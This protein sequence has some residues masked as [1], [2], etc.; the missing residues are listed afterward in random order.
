M[1][2]SPLAFL[3][4]ALLT[5]PASA[6][7]DATSCK[8][9][10]HHVELSATT[11]PEPAQVCISPGQVT[12]INFDG[13]LVPGSMTLDGV[14]RF[15]QA[16]PGA[17]SL[18]LVPSEKLAA[19]ERLRL[20]VRFKDTAAPTSAAFQLIVHPTLAEP[21][22]DVHRQTRPVESFH[23]ELRAR[24]EQV[25]Q[26]EEENARLRGQNA[27]PGG[28]AGLHALSLLDMRAFAARDNSK[29][30]KASKTSA[31]HV[32]GPVASFRATGRVAVTA[33]LVNPEGMA[34]WTAH[35]A[36]LALEGRK[37][38]ELKVLEVWPRAAI[39]PGDWLTLVVEAETSGMESQGP[40]T[41]RIW[42]AE[43]GR[44]A[45]IHGVMLP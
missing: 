16:E 4:P 36:R 38:V 2:A 15:T 37:G 41:L 23:Q 44:T 24:E 18:K 19:G 20:T 21:L 43:G 32:D 35:D 6:E 34:P 1:L 17:S 40:F 8:T 29:S 5:G 39:P 7:P 27:A 13:T 3:L 22:V 31:L 33:R 30:A 14:D 11:P 25:R 45:I 9:G 26:L 28:L 12:L 42:E 10:V